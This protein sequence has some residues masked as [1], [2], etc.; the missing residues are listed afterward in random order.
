[1]CKKNE[2]RIKIKTILPLQAKVKG[3]KSLLPLQ[4]KINENKSLLPLQA[5]V[6][7][8]KGSTT[9]AS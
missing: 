4:A 2:A 9:P 1:M 5:M 7:E 3:N 8:N 6:N